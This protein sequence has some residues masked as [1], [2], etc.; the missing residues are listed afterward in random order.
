[1][2][3]RPVLHDYTALQLQNWWNTKAAVLQ[4]IMTNFDGLILDNLLSLT[5][6]V[7]Q[8]EKQ[9]ETAMTTKHFTIQADGDSTTYPTL[10]A[11]LEQA[12]R[13]VGDKRRNHGDVY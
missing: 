6:G 3:E 10:E 7:I 13:Y 9:K 8:R 2:V 5:R 1:M 12:K 4:E 11:A